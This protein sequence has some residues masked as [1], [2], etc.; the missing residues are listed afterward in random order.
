MSL[1]SY[2]DFLNTVRDG[3]N[4]ST[5]I[6]NQFNTINA[7]NSNLSASFSSQVN[8]NNT[9]MISS[10][11]QMQQNVVYFKLDMMQAFNITVDYVDADGD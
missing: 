9:L 11:D 2:L 8:S 5:I 10:F 3:Q 4:L 6:N 7:A 1:K